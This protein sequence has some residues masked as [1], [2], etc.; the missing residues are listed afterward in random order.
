MLIALFTIFILGGGGPFGPM[1]FIDDA[2][3]NV[4]SAI[5]ED[6]RRKETTATL[7]VMN[8]RSKEYTKAIRGLAKESPSEFSKHDGSDEEI[9]AFWGQ[10]FELN[11]EYTNDLVEMRFELRDQLS[12]DEWEA[13]FP[14]RENS[15]A[16]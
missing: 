2:L 10:F 16:T 15:G 5:V 13:L 12:R 6:D 8:K 7:K 14:A 9:E 1:V 11:S 3:E 4:E